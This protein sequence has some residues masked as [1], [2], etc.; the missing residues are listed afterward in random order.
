[1]RLVAQASSKHP[2]LS[3]LPAHGKSL[4]QSSGDGTGN[5]LTT[6]VKNDWAVEL[7]LCLISLRAT[8]SCSVQI[9]P[10]T[11]NGF[12]RHKRMKLRAESTTVAKTINSF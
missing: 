1:M 5:L 12:L 11:R 10:V 8:M 3:E 9:H 7:I 6:I 2:R 4:M